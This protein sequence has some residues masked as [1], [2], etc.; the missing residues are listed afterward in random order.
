MKDATIP[1]PWYRVRE[2]RPI[3][4]AETYRL[5]RAAITPG[6]QPHRTQPHSTMAAAVAEAHAIE[7]ELSRQ[8]PIEL[9]LSDGRSAQIWACGQC[10]RVA[11]TRA[12][13]EACCKP[14][15]CD[16]CD[17]E[18]GAVYWLKCPKHR[19]EAELRL[20]EERWAK[21]EVVAD[22]SGPI[23][24]DDHDAFV[25]DGDVEEWAELNDI[26]Y[27]TKLR[28]YACKKMTARADAED[29]IEHT[30]D[31]H[32]EDALDHAGPVEELQALLDGWWERYPVVS[33]E[34]DYKH[35]VLFPFHSAPE[36]VV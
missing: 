27:L 17:Q 32:H 25:M 28:T 34:P 23:W 8:K 5:E 33:W 22:Y 13:A 35:K 7:Q 21:A 10:R 36:K 29:V 26:T 19:R 4:T 20:V 9:F 24:V 16:E 18:T 30:L 6:A 1:T 3:H 31:D 11:P 15:I 12:A 14:R 2:A